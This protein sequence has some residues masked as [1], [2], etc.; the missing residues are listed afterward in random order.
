MNY[1]LGFFLRFFMKDTFK[2]FSLSV[3]CGFFFAILSA[4]SCF[5]SSN[6]IGGKYKSK[7]PIAIN[8]DALEVIQQERKAIFTGNVVAIQGDVRLNAEKMTVFYKGHNTPEDSKKSHDVSKKPAQGMQIK[9]EKKA[10]AKKQSKSSMP[11]AGEKNSIEKI[12]VEK[13]VFL[14]TPEETASGDSGIYDVENHKIFLNDNVVL[15]KD[16]NVLKGDNLVYDFDTGKSTM[17][18]GKNQK[19]TNKGNGKARVKALFVPN[20]DEKLPTG[21]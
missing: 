16:K 14:S 21:K 4:Y 11:V 15:T 3:V 13:K 10:D 18:S 5:G 6:P 20:E 12:I 17:S 9:S 2:I 8:S 19:N 7:G 1:R